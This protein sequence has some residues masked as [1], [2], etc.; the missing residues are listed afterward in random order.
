MAYARK[1]A[2]RSSRGTTARRTPARRSYRTTGATRRPAARSGG[3]SS[4]RDIRIVIVREDANPIA[5]PALGL[6][7]SAKPRRPAFG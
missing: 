5:R 3:R 2:R 6:V 1:T 4:Q 7:Q